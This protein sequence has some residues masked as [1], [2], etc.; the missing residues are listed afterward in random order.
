LTYE[1]PIMILIPLYLAY[2]GAVII[3]YLSC[4]RLEKRGEQRMSDKVT[5]NA[6]H[7]R[8]LKG[9]LESCGLKDEIKKNEFICAGCGRTMKI[10]E[11][12][13]IKG[14]EPKCLVYGDECGFKVRSG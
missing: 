1:D 10:D 2:L 13:Y 11:I 7:G 5:I 3:V 4:R 14:K 12:G 8:D 9:F 6:V